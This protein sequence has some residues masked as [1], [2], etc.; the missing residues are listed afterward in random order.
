MRW[1]PITAAADGDAAGGG[2]GGRGGG[3]GGGGR[4]A[5]GGNA[6]PGVPQPVPTPIGGEN[7]CNAPGEGGGGGGRGGFGGGGGLGGP[8]PH[9]MPGTYT[10]A[11]VEGTK[12]LDS[13]PLKITFDPDVKFAVGEHERYNA[14]VTDLHAIQRRGTAAAT[15][16]NSLYPQMTD[17]AKKVGE[18][19]S[20]PAAVKTQFESLQKEFDAARK[21][22]G[23]PL[24]AN[25]AGGRGGGGGGRGGAVDPE[26]V[27]ARTSA[28][29][30]SLMSFWESP[31]GAL[32]RQYNEV[33]LSMPKAIT[34]ANAVLTRAATVSQ[35]LKSYDITLTV[36]PP[37]K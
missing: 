26:N 5:G 4:G 16:L 36:P 13:K 19:S 11:L 34:D 18:N 20:I 23:V 14:M 35:A 12:T 9:A 8:G 3:G 33:K 28:L 2:R 30:N 29:K 10:V 32:V 1:E 31:S 27:L 6:V 21:K 37:V 22:F 17:A 15:A 25:Q 7:P 24:N